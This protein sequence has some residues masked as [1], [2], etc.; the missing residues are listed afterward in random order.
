MKVMVWLLVAVVWAVF[1]GCGAP[2]YALRPG[3]IDPAAQLAFVRDAE[4]L[5]L[6]TGF[7][8]YSE[9]VVK[10]EP[11]E[12]LRNLSWDPSGEKIACF[13]H[14]ERFFGALKARLLVI[15]VEQN[16]HQELGDFRFHVNHPTP[17][18]EEYVMESP[19]WSPDGRWLLVSDKEGIH[20]ISLNGDRRSI[21]ATGHDFDGMLPAA[22]SPD[23]RQCA[24]ARED[25]LFVFRLDG[26]IGGAEE[27]ARRVFD[28]EVTAYSF[29]ADDHLA[30]ATGRSLF[31]V[32][33]GLR[34]AALIHRAEEPIYWTSWRSGGSA[35]AFMTGRRSFR[36]AWRSVAVP[37]SVIYGYYKLFCASSDGQEVH[38]CFAAPL[39]APVDAHPVLSPDGLYIATVSMIHPKV[40]VVA[41]D[42]SSSTQLTME[43]DCTFPAWRSPP[44][45]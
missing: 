44:N 11:G 30:V 42:G 14:C 10:L 36:T 25:T 8:E 43:G 20:Q 39:T 21:S 1:A 29:S 12:T 19:R 5:H 4:E 24:F 45:K 7:S 23:G 38:E 13:A 3:A 35:I 2:R 18:D 22:L 27:V 41:V 37:R 15:D 17:R 9:M 28:D 6:A 40:F 33:V 34:E 16:S 32:D 31:T 26:A